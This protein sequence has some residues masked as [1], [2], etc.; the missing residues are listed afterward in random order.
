MAL[1]L[2]R[3]GVHDVYPLAGGMDEWLRLGLP[4]E[5]LLAG[6]DGSSQVN[7]ADSESGIADS[8]K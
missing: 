6:S 7:A 1:L 8:A 4:V 2:R 5:P 3:H